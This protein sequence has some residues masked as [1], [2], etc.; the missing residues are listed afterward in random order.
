[1]E[2]KKINI[3]DLKH[4]EYN[5]RVDLKPGDREFEKIKK[6][7][8]E[9]GYVEPIIVNSD[10]T[11]IG[12]HQRSKVLKELGYTGVDCIVIEVDKTKEKALNIALNKITGGWDEE[13]LSQLLDD[14]RLEEYNVE[15]TGFDWSE[16]E[17]LFDEHM[18][19]DGSESGEN[20][21]DD[22]E[23]E[24]PEE[25]ISKLGDVWI[26]G[27]HR[28]VV[29]DSTKEED[30]E[31]LMREDRADMV[32]TDPPWNV[33]YGAVSEG[34]AQGYK[35]RTILNDF[36]GTED[37]KEFMNGAFKIMNK[38]SKE[39]AMTYVVMSAQEWGNMMLTLSMNDYHWSSTVIWNKDS[40]VLS[41]KYYHTKY[42]PIWYGWKEG[43]ARL[44]PLGDRKQSDVWDIPRPKVSELHPT[45]KPVD[46]V[47]R[48]IKNSS[49]MKDIVLDLFGGSG[50]TLIACEETD[51][52]CRMMELDPKYADVIVNRYI[53]KVGSSDDVAVLRSENKINYK[54]LEFYN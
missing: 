10:M 2:F 47:I 4:A 11:I 20:P 39:G 18:P 15:L 14:L 53:E 34:N 43:Q 54:N 31:K 41:R 26:L 21:D 12:G 29:G 45:M 25:P 49:D 6:S 36:M 13:K 32:F 28:L 23:I 16:A 35:P 19:T 52:I 37:F 51:R 3:A 48:A 46:L 17:K 50:T 27:K 5:P 1:M 24:L 40:L 44:H 22:F 9:F 33:N 30:V 8:E 7:I 38:F 42:E